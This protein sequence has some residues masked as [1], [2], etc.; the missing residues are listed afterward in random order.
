MNLI[1][2]LVG[3]LIERLATKL[4]HLRQLRRHSDVAP[5][6]KPDPGPAFDWLR[7]YDGLA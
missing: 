4:F 5:G 1:A 2:L 7:L 3:L 6:R